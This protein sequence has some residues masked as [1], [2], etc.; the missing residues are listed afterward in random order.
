[1]AAQNYR[2]RF[3]ENVYVET[4]ENSL[5]PDT[6]VSV[7][8]GPNSP[9]V[10]EHTSRADH[11][12]HVNV[13][14]PVQIGVLNEEGVSNALS[15]AD[16]VHAHGVQTDPTHHAPVTILSNG[17]M[18]AADKIKLD[19][20]SGGVSLTSTPPD[21][22]DAGAS[23]VGVST[24][25]AR[26]DHK[27]HVITGSPVAI[28]TANSDGVSTS[29]SKSDHVHAHG[30]QTDPTHHSVATPIANG[31]MSSI[32][33]LKLNSF[34]AMQHRYV[35]QLNPGDGEFS[36]INAA[37]AAV[38]SPSITNEWQIYVGPGVYNDTTINCIPFVWIKGQGDQQ[39]VINTLSTNGNAVVGAPS[40][41][42]IDCLIQ[43][44]TGINGKG[45]Y[46][47]GVSDIPFMVRNCGLGSN[48]LQ[49]HCDSDA[50]HPMSIIQVADCRLGG[51][52]NLFTTA[53][54]STCS[55]GMFSQLAVTNV[56]YQHIQ[57]PVCTNFA[58]VHGVGSNML[59]ANVD[60]SIYPTA[61]TAWATAY[62]GGQLRA[63]G[64]Y[65]GGFDTV[66]S[67]PNI[68][69]APSISANS[70]EAVMAGTYVINIQHPGT[71]GH[72]FG[73][74]IYNQVFINPL[75]TFYVNKEVAN[76]ITVAEKGGDFTS[77][78]AAVA[79]ISGSSVSNRYMVDVQ[80]GTYTDPLIDLRTKPFVNV[81][82]SNILSTVVI[83][84]GNHDAI[85]FGVCNEVSFLTIRDVPSPYAGLAADD[86]GSAAAAENNF[87]QA[88][89]ITFIH[90]DTGTRVTSATNPTNFFGEYIDYNGVYTYGTYIK[91]TN[92][93]LAFANMENYYNFP[94]G[95][96]NPIGN[97]VSGS[98]AQLVLLA[99]AQDGEAV[100]TALYFEDGADIDIT[101]TSIHGWD[102]GIQ[103]GN[104]GAGCTI[105]ISGAVISN[106]TTT[107]VRI[108]HPAS[109]GGISGIFSKSKF[110][111]AATNVSLFFNDVVDSSLTSVGGIYL[112]RN[113]TVLCDSLELIQ[114]GPAMGVFEPDDSPVLSFG[115]G[116]VV[117]IAAGN[118]YAMTVG[119][120]DVF[121]LIWISQTISIPAS[122]Y[123]Y[124]YFNSSSSLLVSD[125]A[126]PDTRF[127]I[128]LGAAYA[129]ATQVRYIQDIPLIAHHYSNLDDK[130]QREAIGAIF[131]QGCVSSVN[132]SLGVNI[133]Q[134]EYY[135]SQHEFEPAGGTPISWDAYYRSAVPGTYTLIASQSLVDNV[136]YDNGSGT[137]AAIPAGQYAKHLIHLVGGPSESYVLVYGQATY[138]T[139]SAAAAGSL[140]VVPSFIV[141]AFVR[142]CSVIVQQ[143]NAS[144]V[145]FV[146]ERPRIG[147][148]SSSTVGGVTSHG[149]L[150]GLSND[151]HHQY[152][153]TNGSRPFTGSQSLGGNA[154]ISVSSV[155]SVVVEAHAS[156]H[157]PNGADPL[158]TAAPTTTLSFSTS[159]S[160]GI[161]NSLARSD[162]T[163]D[164]DFS[165][166]G[167]ITSGT[168]N[169]TAIAAIYG[170]TGQTV[171]TIGDILYASTTAA[172][173]KLSDIAVGNALISGGVG[174]A[175]S[176]GKVSLTT[177]VSGTLPVAN[178]GTNL[179]TY[180]TG[181]IIYA[182]AT[183][184]LA[185]LADVA[186]GSY[187]LS[188]GV[189]AAPLWSTLTLPNSSTTGDLLFSSASN[190]ISTLADV[191]TGSALVSGGVGVSPS[192]LAYNSIATPNT[193]VSLDGNA[194]TSVNNLLEGYTTIV[195]AGGTTTLTVGSTP[196][197]FFTGTLSQT[198]TM[199]VT[200]TL[201]LGQDFSIT[202]LSTGT[203]TV[204]SSGGGT[205]ATL[206]T[207]QTSDL[208]TILTS[209]TTPASWYSAISATSTVTSFSADGTGLTPATSTTGA[210]TLG[211]VLNTA[212]GG[213]ALSSYTT[214]DIVYA[215]ATNTLA[216]LADVATGNALI[217][218]GV[219][220]AP[221]YGKISLTTTVSGTL[222]IANGG[223]NLTTY[224]TG[225]IVY[226]S[227]TNTLN[228][229]ADVAVGSYLRSGGVT[230]APLWSTLTLPNSSTTGDL[231]YSSASNVIST[232]ADVATGNALI[233]GGVG[234]APSWGKISLTTTV[235]GTLP[236]TNGG[237]NLTTYTTG[238]IVYASATNTLASLADA[239]TGN[240]LIS[241]GVGVA[242]SYG[243]VSLTTTVSG[244]LP[245]AN[246]GTNLTTYTTGDLVY[247]SAT[248]T[249]ASLADAATG[250][251]LISGGVGV[252]PSYGKVSLT[253]TVS[254]TL[255]IANGGT[256]LTTYT[257]GDLVYA[258]A[259]NTLASLA[260]AAT[261][262]ALISGGV[263]VAPSYGKVSLTTT[264]SG[265]LPIANGGTNLTTYT[266][267]DLV[268]ASATNTLNKLAD[269]ATGNAL[270]SGGV[271]VAPS[272]GKIDL[273]TTVTGT[274][275][276]ANGGTGNTSG[277]VTLSNH[278]T[279]T[280][281][282]QGFT[283]ATYTANS[284]LTAYTSTVTGGVYMVIASAW[285]SMSNGS[286]TGSMT[287][288]VG[289]VHNANSK[290]S[291]SSTSTNTMSTNAN[292]TVVTGGDAIEPRFSTT[293]G[294]YT[295]GGCGMS[296][297]RIS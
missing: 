265:T 194:N 157:L 165:T 77:I 44:A 117:N 170:G 196:M 69:V 217:S 19:G 262:N 273:T 181:D 119:G 131:K 271:G 253:T 231:L 41:A 256:N 201:V 195:T 288:Y 5:F 266:T 295:V 80:A 27:H 261:G 21:D 113:S 123:S 49:V 142:I 101:S 132:G 293:G 280:Q 25:A 91:S 8:A 282:S 141:D 212:N 70:V 42:I 188:G 14:D 138:P 258:S 224:T 9:G 56:V 286:Q 110:T 155:N 29:L 260:D 211:G 263:G 278:Q 107:D 81:K 94:V 68:G 226:A 186:A 264:V 47:K 239:A 169:G 252:A 122:S 130:P 46:Y 250:N 108:D 203:V 100:G 4:I 277:Q 185:S 17:F 36:S 243:K 23:A 234:V 76:V 92:G 99:D 52:I 22:V 177:T 268:Y 251:A 180:T 222:P 38:T 255:P 89:K 215:S 10:S 238:D 229:L 124:I 90:S 190:T 161:Q 272:Y 151:D 274:L 240:A 244:T 178:G 95:A 208:V 158:T 6:P 220:V 283:S 87:C 111:S 16:H 59:L 118:G 67:A 154:L 96:P 53:F 37:L 241:G 219:G 183:N 285:G 146:D 109:T 225:D 174:V 171:Y 214:G 248:N 2:V 11:K 200:S 64:C 34:N 115:G 1:M 60:C 40:S 75:S 39:T 13:D 223:T 55:G 148:A 136:S 228:K 249:L 221:S 259:T 276:I 267:G 45:V 189:G 51:A 198:V 287:I 156:R 247:A 134:G 85:A 206:S 139:S 144:I 121:K 242:P 61:G 193:I 133:T 184:T 83:P 126:F 103:N 175:P 105:A 125:V 74:F 3:V 235:S 179:T 129:D 32:D 207:N 93:I 216:S 199:P 230:T 137:L 147:F 164:I 162:H 284:N 128:L 290:R 63:V 31:F 58:V 65:V 66:I 28:G 149:A 204:Q 106:T 191:A 205:I 57:P 297:V 54:L 18:T 232:L 114:H 62:D 173:S 176:Y 167:T 213:T 236:I 143:G 237:T 104:V 150:S 187:L 20:I 82:G 84:D 291:N 116:F 79:S 210:I 102:I 145:Q 296:V 257:T 166:V 98:N 294:T 24:F 72:F 88:H 160:V 135:F 120:L 182:S 73:S 12:H 227:A 97:F 292:V 269:A 30:S 159:N 50:G 245:I 86:C 33:K 281:T 26:S 153:L 279:D 172:L 168:W 289:G 163:H 43:G 48:A 254:G 7:D 192:W 275:P 270:I 15:R 71:T 78:A 197:Q 246:G 202:N 152:I 233:S 209:G 127:N 35:V 140:P 218:G 112:G